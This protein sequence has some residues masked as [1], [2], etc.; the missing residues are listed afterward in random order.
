MGETWQFTISHDLLW[1]VMGSHPLENA[2]HQMD[3]GAFSS[4]HSSTVTDL[5]HTLEEGI[6]PIVIHCLLDPLTE[7]KKKEIDVLVSKLFGSSSRINKSGDRHFFPR[8]SFTRGFC[9][10]S[11]LT[12]DKRVRQLF[13]ISMLL[14]S[15][16]G[17]R[18]LQDRF[19]LDFDEKKS[20]RQEASMKPRVP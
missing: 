16:S 14:L 10:L 15:S 3:M 2:F 12:A 6:I 19:S 7:S 9:S 5:M 13:I 11:L 1:Q 8:V 17:K 20:K 4:I 18:I